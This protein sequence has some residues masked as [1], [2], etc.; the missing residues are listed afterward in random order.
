MNR[1]ALGGFFSIIAIVLGLFVGSLGEDSSLSIKRAITPTLEDSI[2]K[3]TTQMLNLLIGQGKYHVSVSVFRTSVEKQSKR[4]VNIPKSIYTA[5]TTTRKSNVQDIS[6]DPKLRD[7]LQSEIDNLTNK[8]EKNT[9][10]VLTGSR[11]KLS[12]LGP[13][14]FL[15]ALTSTRDS[16][17]TE[18]WEKSKETIYYDIEETQKIHHTGELERISMLLLLDE[19]AVK[20]AGL[21]KKKIRKLLLKALPLK[22]RRGDKMVI[23]YR[24]IAVPTSTSEKLLTWVSENKILAPTLLVL[25]LVFIVVLLRASPQQTILSGASQASSHIHAQ[26]NDLSESTNSS[27][28]SIITM[29]ENQN[30]HLVSQLSEWMNE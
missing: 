13:N 23:E 20:T 19:E 3:K 12:K 17:T 1:V 5:D 11:N 15:N 26:S 6:A 9:S 7:G 16:K 25:A 8:N 30:E 10:S 24:A 28:S 21:N 2:H 22:L 29:A 18:T 4:V 27:S 14:F